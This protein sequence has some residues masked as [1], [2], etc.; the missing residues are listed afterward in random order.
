MANY[1]TSGIRNEFL[2]YVMKWPNIFSKKSSWQLLEHSSLA[3]SFQIRGLSV[4]QISK[5]L[6]KVKPNF[7]IP[8]GSHRKTRDDMTVLLQ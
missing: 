5:I 6:K 1:K 7:L 8:I 4:L 2:I 3:P